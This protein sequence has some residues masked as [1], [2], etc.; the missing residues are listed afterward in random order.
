[1]LNIAKLKYIQFLF[2]ELADSDAFQNKFIERLIK[3]SINVI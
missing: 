3:K 2:Y 1:M